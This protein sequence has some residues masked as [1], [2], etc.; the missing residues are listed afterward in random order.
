MN[1]DSNPIEHLKKVAKALL[2]SV[3]AEDPEALQRVRTIYEDTRAKSDSVVGAEFKLM[4][5]QHAVA[6]EHQF[7]D[8]AAASSATPLVLKLAITM[9]KEPLLTDFGI[10][11]YAGQKNLS[12]EEQEA[13]FRHN[14]MVLRE[15]VDRVEATISWLQEH[16]SPIKTIN[17]NRTSYGYKHLADRDIGYITN[18]VFIAAAIIAGYPYKTRAPNVCFGMSKGSLKEVSKR[19]HQR[20]RNNDVQERTEAAARYSAQTPRQLEL[21][22]LRRSGPGI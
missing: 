2:R 16:V 18:G 1:Q 12:R 10:G 7:R 13:K 9:R 3:Q 5:A 22:A 19:L 4:R 6:I 11:T 8:W 15:S 21:D 20:R 14:R 17:E